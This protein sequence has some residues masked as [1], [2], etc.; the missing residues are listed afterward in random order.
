M[1]A[2]PIIPRLTDIIG[3][4]ER[5]NGVIGDMPLDAFEVDWQNRGLS[6]VALKSFL[7]RAAI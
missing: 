4:I 7:R 5:I 1:M 2:H 3:A 6:S